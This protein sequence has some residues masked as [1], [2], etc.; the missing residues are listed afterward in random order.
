MQSTV[1]YPLYTTLVVLFLSVYGHKCSYKPESAPWRVN[2][3][4]QPEAEFLYVIG[5]NVVRVFLLDIHNHL[6]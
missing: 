3:R 2:D 6:Y 1:T 4:T 5:T